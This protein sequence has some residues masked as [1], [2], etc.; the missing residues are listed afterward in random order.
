MAR[1]RFAAVALLIL[2]LLPMASSAS[3]APPG[4][5][6]PVL[7]P[8]SDVRELT[9]KH[10]DVSGLPM[11]RRVAES[12]A[13]VAAGPTPA[14]G[15]VR[16]W[17]ALDD[18]KGSLYRKDYT[19]RAVGAHIEVWVAEDVAFP[20][21][22]CR[23]AAS[24]EVTDG[25]VNALVR[26]FEETI[27]PRETAAFSVP[28]ERD[29]TKA[30]L[31]GKDYTGAGDKTVTL[32]DNVRDDN[33]YEFPDV[34]TYIAGFFSAQINELVDRNVMTIDAY[35]WRHRSGA[36]PPDEPTGDLCTSRPARPRTYEGT[37]AHE[38]QHLLQSY[39]DPFEDVWVNEGLSDYAQT[40]VGYVDGNAT[41]YHPGYDSHLSCFQGFGLV[42]TRY[43]T[44]PRDCG[45]AQ[46]SLNR[47]NEGAP[48][49]VLADYGIAYQF[50]LYLRDRFGP[51]VLE[52]LHRDREH[53][54]M[55]GVA[56]AL[57][58]GV[59]LSAVLHDFQTMN[60]VDKIVGDTADG[61]MAGAPKSKVTSPSVRAT[62]NLANPASFDYPGAAPNG[63]DYVRLRAASGKFL[64]GADLTSVTFKGAKTLP[65]KSLQWTVQNG[66]L[67][68]GNASSLDVAAVIPVQVP[69]TDPTLRLKARYTTELGY[70]YGYVTV[71]TDGG[72]TYRAVAGDHTVDAPFGPALS[73]KSGVFEP[74]IYDLKAYAGKRV[75]L[76]FRYVSDASVNEGGWLIDDVTVGA[77]TVSDGSTLT[78]W[79][80]PT[81]IVPATVHGWHVKLVGLDEK[82][83]R[84]RQVSVA[85][86]A[87]LRDY[88]KV[89]A[90]VAFDEPTEQVDQYARYTLTA[91]GVVQPGGGS[92]P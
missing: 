6:A 79:R 37:F 44:N 60:L 3:A 48:A 7:P 80:S 21:G 24:I 34:P 77:V 28:R 39:A 57:G 14:V 88:P 68:S 32:V 10:L 36:T 58:P 17:L 64:R 54:G 23:T 63:A 90:I 15:T 19:L 55:A 42:R 45:G 13:P 27:Y 86:Y 29:G 89:V 65:P 52:R 69:A 74:Q 47:W 26:E 43:N 75:L 82:R 66:A 16:E 83:R 12:R 62:V 70:D 38:W 41:V 1:L 40:L 33:Y 78:G 85:A 22:D 53:Q 81:Q 76:G 11:R 18:V 31:A 71:S 30:M 46:N 84:A 51:A 50:M 4:P 61:V 5:A 9:R 20:A 67:F 59:K 2:P 72:K 25:Q 92:T 73:G 87:A 49:E 56:A 91:N 35:D 8:A